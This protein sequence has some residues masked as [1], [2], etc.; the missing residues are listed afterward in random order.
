MKY[1]VVYL[2]VFGGLAGCT[3]GP[4]YRKVEPVVPKHWQAEPKT[5]F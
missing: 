4:D 2:L 3:M 1:K 5:N